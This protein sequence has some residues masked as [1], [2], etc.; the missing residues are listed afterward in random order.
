MLSVFSVTAEGAVEYLDNAPADLLCTA[1]GAD[2]DDFGYE[3]FWYTEVI[4][5]NYIF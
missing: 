2:F 5:G 4:I 3:V 1:Q